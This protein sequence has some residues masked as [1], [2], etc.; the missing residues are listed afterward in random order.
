ME[1]WARS[2]LVRLV[3]ASWRMVKV[4]TLNQALIAE[5]ERLTKLAGP[6]ESIWRMRKEEL[7][8]IAIAELGVTRTQAS[9]ETVLVL[10][11]RI[12][13]SRKE[14][15]A[16]SYPLQTVPVGLERMLVEQ[17]AHAEV[18][19]QAWR[20]GLPA[21]QPV[22]IQ[23]GADLSTSPERRALMDYIVEMR[24]ILVI[25]ELPCTLWSSVSWVNYRG[26]SG[27]RKLEGRRREQQ[28][29]LQLA[30][31]IAHLKREGG[32]DFLMENPQ[33]SEARWEPIIRALEEAE[34]TRS[35]INHMCRFGLRRRQN[36]PVEA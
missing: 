25:V 33:T 24:P 13:R 18:S 8:E 2:L 26:T 19:L 14:S 10:R 30:S 29:F 28:P 9:K 20:H 4:L 1:P 15:V 21:L 27:R 17:V 35:T 11:E 16:Q 22:D 3:F 34:W 6:I 36:A 7:I 12:R 23:Y 31:D 5:N 32:D